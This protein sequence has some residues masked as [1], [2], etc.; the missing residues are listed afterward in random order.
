MSY[1]IASF[2]IKMSQVR[3]LVIISTFSCVCERINFFFLNHNWIEIKLSDSRRSL[4]DSQRFPSRSYISKFWL[5]P[6]WLVNSIGRALHRHR[7]GH[8]PVRAWI[9]FFRSYLPLLVSVVYIFRYMNF[10]IS[11][12]I[13][14]LDVYLGPIHW[15][16][17][18][19]LV[20]SIGRALHWYRRG[21][22]FNSRTSLN[23]FQVLFTTTRFSSVLS[24]EDLLISLLRYVTLYSFTT[25]E[26]K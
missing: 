25:L 14:N 19:W 12:I 1:Q 3:R 24:C 21:H 7:R 8:V 18:S 15:S 4:R 17:S 20:S 11:K 10:H 6:S 16:A 22:G 5:A 13:I 23:F 26:T 9:F 2:V